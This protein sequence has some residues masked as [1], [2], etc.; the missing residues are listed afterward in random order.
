MGNQINIIIEITDDKSNVINRQSIHKKEVITNASLLDLGY[1][2]REQIEVLQSIQNALLAE[3]APTVGEHFTECP[4]C[5]SKVINKGKVASEFHSVF[6]DHKIPN[7]ST[8][9]CEM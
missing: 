1:R 9:L 6:T 7:P 2:H 5:H 8:I 4:N 3:Q